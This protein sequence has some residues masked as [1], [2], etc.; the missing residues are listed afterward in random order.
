MVESQTTI[1]LG[2]HYLLYLN[3]KLG[4][5]AFGEIYLGLNQKNYQEVAIKL[6]KKTNKPQLHHE[7]RILKELQNGT[8]IPKIF[9]FHQLQNFSC[10]IQELLGPSLENLFNLCNRKFSLKTTLI[11]AIQMLNRIEFMHNRGIIHR[12]IKPDNFLMGKK[13]KDYLLY[14]IDMG[15]SKRYID[16]KTQKHIKFKEGKNLTGT[17]RYASIFTHKGYEQSR[18]DDIEGIS[19][20]LI[21][22]LKGGL[23]WQGQKGKNKKERYQKIMD[24]KI[25][26][27]IEDLCKDLPFEFIKFVSYPR[28]L[29]FEEKPDY[30]FLK[31]LLHNIIKREDIKVDYNYD[32]LN[33]NKKDEKQKE[34]SENEEKIK[35]FTDENINNNNKSNNKNNNNIFRIFNDDVNINMN[36]FINNFTNLKEEKNIEIEDK[37]IEK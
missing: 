35:I 4:N 33:L 20:V 26:T 31:S 30:D 17:V 37:K 34:R 15:L 12:D 2:S 14:I 21:Y 6:E 32:W 22:F 9:Y 19:Y 11:L 3:K 16:P 36:I 23:P 29:I 25:N 18:R 28:N 10:L 1:K 13:E 5:G 24:I 27:K 7:T 8:G